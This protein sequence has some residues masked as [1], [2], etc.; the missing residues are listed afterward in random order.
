MYRIEADILEELMSK[1]DI[2]TE[3]ANKVYCVINSPM[4]SKLADTS[5][6]LRSQLQVIKLMNKETKDV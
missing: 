3:Q 6:Q 2:I 4:T 5:M 1:S